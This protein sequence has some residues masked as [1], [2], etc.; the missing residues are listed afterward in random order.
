MQ[1]MVVNNGYPEFLP[2]EDLIVEF[3][4]IERIGLIDDAPR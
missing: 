2:K 4:T 1:L 3:G